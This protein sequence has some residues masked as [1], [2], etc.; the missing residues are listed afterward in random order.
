MKTATQTMGIGIHTALAR[1]WAVLEALQQ[2]VTTNL[3]A[4]AWSSGDL[5]GLHLTSEALSATIFWGVTRDGALIHVCDSDFVARNWNSIGETRLSNRRRMFREVEAAAAH[6]QGLLNCAI[7]AA[8]R[9]TRKATGTAT[10][11]K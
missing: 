4:E 8:K 11:I 1:A 6:V 7:R 3:T 2:P 10:V 9:R 5:Q